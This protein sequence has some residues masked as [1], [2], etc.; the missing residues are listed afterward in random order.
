[1]KSTHLVGIL[2]VL[3]SHG[4]GCESDAAPDPCEALACG[5]HAHCVTADATPT[6]ACDP[7]HLEHRG[8]GCGPEI[9]DPV[10]TPDGWC[11]QDAPVPAYTLGRL[12]A[13]PGDRL[14]VR[15]EGDVLLWRE[16]DRWWIDR[17]GIPD[18]VD[19]LWW[20]PSGGLLAVDGRDQVLRQTGGGWSAETVPDATGLG[21]VWGTGE[22]ALW[23]AGSQWVQ[24][25]WEAHSEGQLLRRAAGVWTPVWSSG[26]GA[27]ARIAGSGPADVWAVGSHHHVS[28]E[29]VTRSSLILHWDGTEV[30]VGPSE[31]RSALYDL[32]VGE[33]GDVWA[34]G[35]RALD[36]SYS[37]P[38]EALLLHHD[39]SGWSEVPVPGGLRMLLGVTGDGED[40]VVLGWTEVATSAVLRRRDGAWQELARSPEHGSVNL[41]G[42]AF[43]AEGALFLAGGSGTLIRLGPGAPAPGLLPAHAPGG[44]TTR[45]W[46]A[47]PDDVWAVGSRQTAYD[48][49]S[50]G[51]LRHFDGRTWITLPELPVSLADV[52]GSGPDDVWFVGP[53][54]WNG[55]DATV[56]HWDGIALT[57][58]PVDVDLPL[59]AVWASGPG[60]AWALGQRRVNDATWV[61]ESFVYHWDGATWALDHHAPTLSL[62]ALSGTAADD[63]WAVGQD[64]AT[65]QAVILHHDG[66]SWTPVTDD[67]PRARLYAV[68][69]RT[70]D[71]VWACG[72]R[73]LA[74]DVP[75][76][77]ILMH[78]EGPGW[79]EVPVAEGGA[80]SAVW[81]RSGSEVYTGG[82]DGRLL[83]WD[84]EAWLQQRTG[85]LGWVSA[86]FGVED[87]TWLL[88]GL[89]VQHLDRERAA[90]R[91]ER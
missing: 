82:E 63:L 64:A 22:D 85:L 21:V 84:G 9:T 12:L 78:R 25:Q 49:P 72:I 26:S 11:F 40:L 4:A 7:G 58:V 34:A 68:Q 65:G 42:I 44:E 62:D 61:D 14:L 56:L 50:V 69:A 81:A 15:A 47:S 73:C 8:G 2:G 60:D 37:A 30:Q 70:R 76:T 36:D 1:M 16:D 43:D 77:G 86:I 57:G 20:D 13:G 79:V 89:G 88:G 45:L 24:G 10:C 52:W 31:P 39:G 51:I 33:P 54:G 55:G 6:C 80:L 32:W 41:G 71:D 19:D 91:R 67:L 74:L 48:G 23:V 75:C 5:A 29:T 83:R 59:H 27:V 35:M 46:G 66:T 38:S 28:E 87:H 53:A 90:A 17:A 3:L 18:G